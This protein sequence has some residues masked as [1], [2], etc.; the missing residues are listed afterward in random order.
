MK[1]ELAQKTDQKS[2]DIEKNGKVNCSQSQLERNAGIKQIKT[3]NFLI[4]NTN[5]LFDVSILKI[6]NLKTYI[7]L[8]Y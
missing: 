6:C 1:Q 3:K 2:M 8:I 7:Q 5:C 4:I